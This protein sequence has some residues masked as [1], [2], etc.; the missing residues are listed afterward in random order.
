MAQAKSEFRNAGPGYTG[1][2]VRGENGIGMTGIS[3]APGDK[4]WLDEDEQSATANAPRSDEDNPFINGRL[5]LVTKATEVANRRP[6][7][8]TTKPQADQ[9][10]SEEQP[11]P[12]PEPEP[13]ATEE[14]PAAPETEAAKAQ[15]VAEENARAA[16]ARR[17]APAPGDPVQASPPPETQGTEVA[18]SDQTKTEGKRAKSEEVGTPTAQK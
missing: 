15:R 2:L 1:V 9:A 14:P 8:D 18:A 6:I 11:A 17:R 13:T 5:E 4:I 12:T 7:G 3:V 10:S 16:S